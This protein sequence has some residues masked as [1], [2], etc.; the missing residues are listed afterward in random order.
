MSVQ[1]PSVRVVSVVTAVGQSP[2]PTPQE[3]MDSAGLTFPV[4]MDDSTG[5]IAAAFGITG[6]PTVYWI[7]ASG[8]VASVTVGEIS[9]Q[10]MRAEFAAIAGG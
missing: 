3:F 4:A 7:D 10:Q 8:H 1:F 6:F 2:G 5:S 9:D